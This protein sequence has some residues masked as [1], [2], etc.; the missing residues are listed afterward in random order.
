MAA[1][2]IISVVG[3][4]QEEG[5]RKGVCKADVQK[6]CKG[7]RPGQGRIWACLKSREAELSQQ[8]VDHMNKQREK[9]KGF[10]SA[11]KDDSKKFCKG[12]PHGKGRIISCLTSHKAELSPGCQ[13]FFK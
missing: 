11:C 9:A 7:I 8:C 1:L 5:E 10:R 2:F 12:I 6:F 3:F 13:S 4:T